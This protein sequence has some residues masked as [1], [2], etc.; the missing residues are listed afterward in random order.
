MEVLV[1]TTLLSDGVNDE[2]I[3][4]IE[5]SFKVISEILN[6]G[7]MIDE[8]T[9]LEDFLSDLEDYPVKDK[10]PLDLVEAYTS[11]MLGKQIILDD[12]YDPSDDNKIS[13]LFMV[14][15]LLGEQLDYLE[16]ELNCE[17]YFVYTLINDTYYGGMFAFYNKERPDV[18]FIQGITKIFSPSIISIYYPEYDKLLPRLNSLLEPS[19]ETL[20]K[21]L[22]A[23]KILV[24]PIGKQGKILK[25]HYGYRRWTKDIYYPC[26]SIAGYLN[27]TKGGG[28]YKAYVKYV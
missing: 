6:V 28:R 5:R 26:E 9:N 20:A 11:K 24:V 23:D 25:K 12:R 18:L 4:V 13:K 27:V 1:R 17:A 21:M 22:N 19:I 16:D 3:D 14:R 7:E 2:I 15:K 10:I 8:S